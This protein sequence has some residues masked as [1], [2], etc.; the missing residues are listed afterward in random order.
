[1]KFFAHRFKKTMC[2]FPNSSQNAVQIAHCTALIRTLI[3][4]Y[5]MVCCVDMVWYIVLYY[6]MVWYIIW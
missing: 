5:G 1:M 6:S 3:I 2:S 4:W